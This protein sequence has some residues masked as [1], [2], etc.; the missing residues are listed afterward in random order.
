MDRRWKAH[1]RHRA[2]SRRPAARRPIALRSRAARL[3]ARPPA[4]RTVQARRGDRPQLAA[5]VAPQSCYG[6]YPAGRVAVQVCADQRVR[7]GRVRAEFVAVGAA[8][9]RHPTQQANLAVVEQKPGRTGQ[10]V[11]TAA[12]GHLGALWHAALQHVAQLLAHHSYWFTTV[13]RAVAGPRC[14]RQGR[15]ARLR[16]RRAPYP[17]VRP[18]RRLRERRVLRPLRPP[19]HRPPGLRS[20]RARTTVL[21]HPAS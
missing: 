13:R 18:Q 8:A 2:V 12:G 4:R 5:C 3:V 7:A 19:D 21:L 1:G 11:L 6:R 9:V 15:L 16:E 10:V 14:G 20:G 17:R